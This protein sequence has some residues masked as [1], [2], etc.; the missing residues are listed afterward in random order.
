MRKHTKEG[1]A[2]EDG[3]SHKTD[4]ENTQVLEFLGRREGRGRRAHRR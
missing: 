3:R 1:E 4:E 2:V